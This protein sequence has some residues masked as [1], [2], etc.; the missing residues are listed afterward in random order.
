MTVTMIEGMPEP[1][2]APVQA[3]GR[4]QTP[5]DTVA[6]L[7]VN[8]QEYTRWKSIR[9]RRDYGKPE[10]VF[11]FACAEPGPYGQ[12]WDALR[13][14]IGDRADV[15]LG[16]KKAATCWI[17]TRTAAYDSG[18]HDLVVS[19]KSIPTDL[20]TSSV[21]VRPGTFNGQNFEQVARGIMKPHPVGLVIQN[22]PPI[23]TKPFKSLV[24]QYGETVFEMLNRMC[25]MRGV[26]MV[27]DEN[28]NLVV[29]RGDPSAAPVA[30]LVEGRNIKSARGTLDNQTAWHRLD[31]TGQNVGDDD[32]WPPR[33]FTATLT[34]PNG[35]ANITKLMVA[36]HP[37]DADEMQQRANIELARA[38]WAVV[39][40]TVVVVGWKQPD[41]S[42]WRPTN[43]VLV[44]S[45]M[46]FPNETGSLPLGIQAV[47]F[48]QDAQ[49]GSTT[50]LSLV[51]PQ[52]LSTQGDLNAPPAGG[53][54]PLQSP[55][56]NQAQPV[57]AD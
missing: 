20:C 51:L 14:N 11:T 17:T 1:K 52:A 50:T 42:L 32:N 48:A 4:K 5:A 31:I 55:I 49:N 40:V 35:R 29:G 39:N 21:D 38:Y 33:D 7:V 12:G 45:P 18:N 6:H 47:E 16:G 34:N 27:D 22:P 2:S 8:G 44:R 53:S 26:S 28:G 10:S 30:E 46:L 3:L 15:Y 25:M 36:E 23:F 57:P 54:D 9:V 24:P 37:G 43:N 19:G 13:L 41:G 56:P